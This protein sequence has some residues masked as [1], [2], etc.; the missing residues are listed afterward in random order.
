M[1]ISYVFNKQ[2]KHNASY[3]SKCQYETKYSV[4]VAKLH[5]FYQTESFYF[6]Y[7]LSVNFS[8]LKTF[9]S[10]FQLSVTEDKE[11]LFFL[12]FPVYHMKE[13]DLNIVILHFN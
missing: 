12:V 3:F 6:A 2:D 5:I 11:D 8:N 7:L 10:L 1:K 4:S 9:R 13:C